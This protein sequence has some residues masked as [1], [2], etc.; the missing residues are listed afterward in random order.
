[1][2][3]EYNKNLC[4]AV[5]VTS[6]EVTQI[7][8]YLLSAIMNVPFTLHPLPNHFFNIS[9]QML[10]SC[11]YLE[12]RIYLHLVNLYSMTCTT[13]FQASKILHDIHSE[14]SS[15]YNPT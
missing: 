2:N 3:L 14:F 10:N 11:I 6:D 9:W 5:E 1:M 4:V 7:S 15:F 13:N 12:W 8:D